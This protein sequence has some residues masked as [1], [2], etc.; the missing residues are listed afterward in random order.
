MKFE[1]IKTIAVIG[2]GAMGA[3]MTEVFSRVG[4]YAVNMVD[5]NDDLVKK[6]L[7]TIDNTLERFFVAKG[8]ITPQEKEDITGRIK[9]G[10]NMEDAVKD[11]DFV[12]EAVPEILGLKKEVFARLDEAAPQGII[13][14]SNTS[15][16]NVTEIA[17]ATKRPESVV[18]MHFFNPVAVM[19]LVEVVK[20]AQTSDETVSVVKD[21]ALKVKKEPVVCRDTSFGFLANRAYEALRLEAVQMVWEKVASPEDVD[22]S[23]K[24]GYNI[25]VGPLEMGDML[26]SWKRRAE[27]EEDRIKELGDEKGRL[28]PLI[29]AMVR[30]G[31]SGGPGNKGIYDFW[32]E[33]MSKW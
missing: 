1:E 30:A 28:H 8:K 19:K 11:A 13:L 23:L 7:G 17:I 22:K 6:G 33:V 26:A 3:Q 2:S 24:L 31:Y 16:L 25:P 10:T 32:K 9:G 4:G 12:I 21:L 14:A 5:T 15:M 27:M 18:G 20:G 29:K